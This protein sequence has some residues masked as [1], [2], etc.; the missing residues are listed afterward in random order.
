[1][2]LQKVAA[3]GDKN[4]TIHE[5]AERNFSSFLFHSHENFELLYFVSGEIEY[6]IEENSYKLSPGDLLVLPPGKMHRAVVKDQ[7]ALYRRMKVDLSVE[8][9]N[10]LM[11]RAPD[12]FVYRLQNAYCVSM[13]GE[14]RKNY[15]MLLSHLFALKAEEK[16]ARDSLLT[17]LLLVIDRALARQK[18]V[19]S[20]APAMQRIQ[21]VIEYINRHLSDE[22]SLEFL[23]REFYISKYHLSRQFK[24]YTNQTIHTYINEKRMLSAAAQLQDGIRPQ[25]VAE[26]LGFST[27][28]GFHR[29][30]V[31]KYSVSPSAYQKAK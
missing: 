1:M 25:Q 20:P 2:K 19:A 13:Q 17:L 22:L 6:Y 24:I 8:L 15:E 30:F 9:A 14:E 5:N 16:L 4:V 27:Y 23:A 12:S 31:Q 26:N 7:T 28:A 3:V 21:K 18:V 29:A 10:E 11:R